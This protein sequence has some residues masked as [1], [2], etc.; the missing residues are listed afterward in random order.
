[1]LVGFLTEAALVADVDRWSPDED[2]AVLL[3]MHNAKGLEFPVVILAGLEEGLLP[4]S[5]ALADD[6]ELEEER[7]LFYVGLTR[8]RDEV[9]LSAASFRRRYDRPGASDLSRFVRE[10]PSEFLAV[11]NS[12][13]SSAPSSYGG[14]PRA[15]A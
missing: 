2:R 9:I 7:R 1:S 5:S 11:E 12:V 13:R 6:V 4:H 14:A 10:I 8:A 3:T 15:Y